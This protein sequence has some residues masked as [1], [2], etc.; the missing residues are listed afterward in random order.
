MSGHREDEV[1]L[2]PPAPLSSHIDKFRPI[3]QKEGGSFGNPIDTNVDIGGMA[4]VHSRSTGKV[5]ARSAISTTHPATADP[6]RHLGDIGQYND[7]PP[8]KKFKQMAHKRM[9]SCR[10]DLSWR[11]R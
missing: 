11:G 2:L 3:A 6:S 4:E 10:S 8:Y 1:P 7:L 5:V 9:V